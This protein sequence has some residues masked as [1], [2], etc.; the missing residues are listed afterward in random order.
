MAAADRRRREGTR[1]EAKARASGRPEL[2]VEPGGFYSL[3][4]P[5]ARC[6]QREGWEAQDDRE[7]LAVEVDSM[8][9]KSER[10]EIGVHHLIEV[11][12]FLMGC[13]PHVQ[14]CGALEAI[15]TLVVDEENRGLNQEKRV[16]HQSGHEK[17]AGLELFNSKVWS[18]SYGFEGGCRVHRRDRRRPLTVGR[19]V[20]RDACHT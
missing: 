19:T 10:P 9:G 8:R 17:G 11:R 3:S 20:G 12:R 13:S 6:R 18:G 5:Q 1:A 7:V 16:I 14:M 2:V 4:P 15:S